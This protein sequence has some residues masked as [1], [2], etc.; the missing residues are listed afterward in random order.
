MANPTK[1]AYKIPTSNTDGSPLAPQ[2]IKQID[3]GIGTT[4]GQYTML[5]PDVTFTPGP[6]GFSTEPLSAFGVLVPGTYFA[7]ART[8][9]KANI[10]SDWSNEAQFTIAPP[11][12]NPPTGFTVA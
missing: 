3:I 1:I 12:H 2:E 6:D 4:S 10:M 8:V 9:S 11:I 5:V 7:A